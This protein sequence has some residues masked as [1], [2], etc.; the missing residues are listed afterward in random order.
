MA[1]GKR[2]HDSSARRIPVSSLEALGGDELA[3]TIMRATIQAAPPDHFSELSRGPLEV[4]ALALSELRAVEPKLR[5][6]KTPWKQRPYWATRADK[7]RAAVLSSTTKLRITPQAT[8]SKHS[9]PHRPS[10]A[11]PRPRGALGRN[12]LA[13]VPTGS[14]EGPLH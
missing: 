2:S 4:Y 6:P 1:K 3:R 7:C 13:D 11:P 12:P 10:S 5:D 8:T 9:N 14:G